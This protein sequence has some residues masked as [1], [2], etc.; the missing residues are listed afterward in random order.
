MEHKFNSKIKSINPDGTITVYVSPA[1][2]DRDNEYIPPEEWNLN[3]FS[4]HPVL[5]T[6]H[7]WYGSIQSNIGK[8][9]NWGTDSD[10]LWMQFEYFFGQGND[11]ADWAYFLAQKGLAAFSV[12]FISKE[13]I[14]G[15]QISININGKRPDRVLKKNE[16]FE[17]SQVL[18]PAN[19]DATQRSLSKTFKEFIAQQEKTAE[20][21]VETEPVKQEQV[22]EPAKTIVEPATVAEPEPVT[23]KTPAEAG[24]PEAVKDPEEEAAQLIEEYLESKP[25]E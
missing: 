8:A 4:K 2:I 7:N 15:E 23:D 9:V 22:E 25:K 5:L 16:L 19:Q 10:G 21:E 20:P 18:I 1:V 11:E 24:E 17:V 3:D 14:T 12:G 6:Q 13:V